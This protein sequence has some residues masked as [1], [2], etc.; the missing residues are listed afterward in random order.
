MSVPHPLQLM[1][2]CSNES[3]WVEML[4]QMTQ[5]LVFL[6][7]PGRSKNGIHKEWK[8]NKST[9][10]VKICRWKRFFVGKA[11]AM[12]CVSLVILEGKKVFD[13]HIHM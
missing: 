3:K 8:C 1:K 6:L 10:L 5:L 12:R 7:N 11:W 2:L 13:H 4:K 9:I